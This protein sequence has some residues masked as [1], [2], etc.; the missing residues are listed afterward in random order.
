MHEQLTPTDRAILTELLKMNVP[1]SR[2]AQLHGKHCST[3]YRELA[4][5]ATAQ[6]ATRRSRK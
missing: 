6:H 1:K 5:K 2:I 3:I 4:R